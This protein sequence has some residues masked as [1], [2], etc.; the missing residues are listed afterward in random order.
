MEKNHQGKCAVGILL[1]L[2]KTI[3][4]NLTNSK[5]KYS[6]F[7][8]LAV[9]PTSAPRVIKA[10]DLINIWMQL[11][12]ISLQSVHFLGEMY[13]FIPPAQLDDL[14]QWIYDARDH[15][16]DAGVSVERLLSMNTDEVIESEEV[17]TVF[18]KYCTDS[19]GVTR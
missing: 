13:Y 9:T 12:K 1:L 3:K 10:T 19:N 18:Y 16:Y 11:Q 8:I 4:K 6:P 17:G 5:T 7:T 15:C 14:C 2:T